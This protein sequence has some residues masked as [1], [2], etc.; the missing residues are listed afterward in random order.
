MCYDGMLMWCSIDPIGCEDVDDALC[1]HMLPNGN[2]ELSVHIAD[3]SYFV[4]QGELDT[5]HMTCTC[6]A[7]SQGPFPT[8]RLDS[9]APPYTSLTDATTCCRQCDARSRH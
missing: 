5:F 9:A 3:V 6:D 7:L 8:W 4:K 2:R 1:V